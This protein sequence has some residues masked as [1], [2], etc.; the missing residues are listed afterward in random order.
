MLTLR[1]LRY[2]EALS[3]HLHF[4]RAAEECA[5]TQPALSMQIREMEEAHGVVLLERGRQGVR[6]TAI[7]EV[8]AHRARVV[9]SSIQDLE[10][11]LRDHTRLLEGQLRLGVIPTIAPYLLPRL[12]PKLEKHHPGLEVALRE[13]VTGQLVSALTEGAL[14]VVI[15]S[16]PVEHPEL[17]HEV[18]FQDPFFLA[19]PPGSD[20]PLT[21]PVALDDLS[22][23]DLLLLED[24]H[25]LRDQALNLCRHVD[26]RQ[27]R[28]FGA[29]SLTTLVEMVA[30]GQG[31]TLLPALFLDAEPNVANRLRLL[32]FQSPGPN[33]EIGLVWRRTLPFAEDVAQLARL[34]RA[35]APPDVP[36]GAVPVGKWQDSASVHA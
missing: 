7:G 34:I 28:R 6:L 20:S 1:Q 19:L 18:L 33:R 35:C 24:G 17:E 3:R 27:L 14:D 15:M 16:L 13:S 25:C 29:S 11:T 26:Q 5:I 36:S 2:F 31:S 22:T 9:L 21:A 23:D 30:S 32:P 4:G 12:L 8:A 10:R